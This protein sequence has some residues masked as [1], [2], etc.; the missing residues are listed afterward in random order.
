MS[1][2]YYTDQIISSSLSSSSGS[3]GFIELHGGEAH[4]LSRVCRHQIGEEIVLFDGF[5]SEAKTRIDY[6]NKS[7]VTLSIIS[8]EEID[9]ELGLPLHLV[10]SAPKADRMD[11]LIE[12][13]TELGVSDLTW[14]ITERT[15]VIPALNKAEK[16]QRQ[17]I[18]ASKQCGRNC[19]MKIH[20]AI[21][22]T[23]FLSQKREYA[24]RGIAHPKGIGLST[25]MKKVSS[26]PQQNST[27][28]SWNQLWPNGITFLI[29]PEGG[30][31]E[32][33]VTMAIEQQ[34]QPI[35]LGKRILRIETAATYLASWVGSQIENED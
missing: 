23:T 28:I 14:L 5:G 13:L 18:E 33:E 20:Q 30:F 21:E 3:L 2:R 10:V 12:K 4:H 34:Y 1:N 31:T 15:V 16:W 19:L 26:E 32:R 22:L 27:N 8:L 11:Y 7:S 35:S 9:R 6:I 17:V 29:G 25:L 24:L